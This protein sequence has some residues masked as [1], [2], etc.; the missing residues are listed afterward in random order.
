MRYI[1]PKITGT[2]P[3]VSVIQNPKIGM[4]TEQLVDLPTTG[5]AYQADE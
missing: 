1:Q 2:F 5:N 3:A 4:H